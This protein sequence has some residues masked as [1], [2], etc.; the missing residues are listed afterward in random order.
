M[1]SQTGGFV[2]T[3]ILIIVS[4]VLDTLRQVNSQLQMR[5][6]ETF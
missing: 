3:T 2:I 6:Y 5:E 1:K 4:V